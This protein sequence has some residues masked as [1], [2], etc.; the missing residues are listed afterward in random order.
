MI[1]SDNLRESA[2]AS[3]QGSVITCLVSARV[4]DFWGTC[5]TYDQTS[6]RS[7]IDYLEDLVAQ[8]DLY[9]S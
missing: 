4:V 1:G 8:R 9:D 7:Q 2:V 6:L 3:T 5:T